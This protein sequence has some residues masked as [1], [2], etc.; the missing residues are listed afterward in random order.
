MPDD[1]KYTLCGLNGLGRTDFVRVLGSVF[2]HSPWIVEAAW[3]KLPFASL[4]DLHRALCETV[5]NS[6][7]EQQLALVRA[8]P[9]LAGHAALNGALTR[10]SSTE[11]SDAGLNRLSPAELTLFQKQNAAYR[12]TFGFPFV[13]CAR[14]NRPAAI[15]AAFEHRLKKPPDE[16]LKTALEEIFKIAELRIRDLVTH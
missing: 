15:L 12:E 2:E 6:G 5:R 1:K 14:L 10:E 9:D 13:I 16:E 8:H 3:S 11:Q 4:E 7:A